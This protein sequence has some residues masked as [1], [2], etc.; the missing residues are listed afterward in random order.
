MT[1]PLIIN[2]IPGIF[3]F[4]ALKSAKKGDYFHI[5]AKST[6]DMEVMYFEECL[7]KFRVL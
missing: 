4:A 2:F 5:R 3:R 7:I 6:P 1:Y